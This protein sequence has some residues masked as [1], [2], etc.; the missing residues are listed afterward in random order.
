MKRIVQLA[1]A[2]ELLLF[3]LFGSNSSYSEKQTRAEH[4]Y[5]VRQGIYIYPAL[6]PRVSLDQLPSGTLTL[7]LTVTTPLLET[8]R[9]Q[10]S[11]IKYFVARNLSLSLVPCLHQRLLHRHPALLR[12]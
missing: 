7:K 6:R 11:S 10:P 12:C 8:S 1:A 5:I 9:W 4:A 3:T 2:G